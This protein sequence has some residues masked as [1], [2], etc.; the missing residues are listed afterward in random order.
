ML[1]KIALQ[2]KLHLGGDAIERRGAMSCQLLMI[3]CVV[4]A[5]QVGCGTSVMITSRPSKAEVVMDKKKVLGRT[6]ILLK[7]QAW[8]WTSHTLT[9]RKRGYLTEQ[10]RLEAS[11]FAPNLIICMCMWPLWPMVMQANYPNSIVVHLKEAAS[12]SLEPTDQGAVMR[13]QAD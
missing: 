5:T 6:P 7:E 9:F 10:R 1:T 11:F 2:G 4:G 12:A 3:L 13:F 8:L